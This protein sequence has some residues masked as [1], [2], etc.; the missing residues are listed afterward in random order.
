MI[1]TKKASV[2]A[3]GIQ[4]LPR[5]LLVSIVAFVV[6]GI[7][8]TLYSHTI[9]IRSAEAMLMT[10]QI[11]D[12]IAPEGILDLEKYSMNKN[13]F[14]I[15]QIGGGDLDRFYVEAIVKDPD[16]KELLKLFSGDS[17]ATWIRE[18]FDKATKNSLG[19]I[20]TSQPGSFSKDYSI[21]LKD[22][23]AGKLFV[24]VFV[25]DEK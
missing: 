23:S 8:N 9:N 22:G 5:L 16:D 17:G 11:V 12:C 14:F 4:M 25:K 13:L 24:E 7:S 21:I 20:K 19:G 1:S 10:R 6:L 15:C 18:L 3:E 2:L